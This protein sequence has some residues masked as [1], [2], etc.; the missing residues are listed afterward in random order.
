MAIPTY[1][2]D[3]PKGKGKIPLTPQYIINH[4]DTLVFENYQGIVCTYPEADRE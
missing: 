2:L 4:G 3:G 1:A